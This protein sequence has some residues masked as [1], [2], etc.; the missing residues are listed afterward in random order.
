VAGVLLLLDQGRVWLELVVAPI[1]LAVG[2]VVGRSRCVFDRHGIG[3]DEGLRR[4]RVLWG[5]IDRI[6]L[7]PVRW[8]AAV[9]LGL[10]D[11]PSV[12]VGPTWG[13]SER[14][15]REVFEAIRALAGAH[16]VSVIEA[17]P[18]ADHSHDQGSD[19]A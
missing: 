12:P 2:W 17:P 9:R 6:E 11:R 16:G 13:L 18:R 3:L 5:T 1:A 8:H 14:R 19:T 7:R 4:S 15:R 10:R